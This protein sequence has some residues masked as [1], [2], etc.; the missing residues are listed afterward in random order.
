MDLQLGLALSSFYDKGFDLNS[1]EIEINGETEAIPLG[2]Q[3]CNIKKRNF[4]EVFEEKN[5][6]VP[7]LACDDQTNQGDD[8]EESQNSS[9]TA[10][11]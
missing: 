3:Q 7:L 6:D 9:I 5:V 4:L 2:N 1:S 8:L 10:N 11:K